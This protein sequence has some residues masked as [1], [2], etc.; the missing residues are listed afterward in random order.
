MNKIIGV[1]ICFFLLS[2]NFLLI[3]DATDTY[4]PLDGGWLEIK[5][6]VKI[7]HLSGT[8]YEMGYQHGFLL[9][10]EIPKNIRML[11]TLFESRGMSYDELVNKW[12]ILKE[13]I[14]MDYKN[15]LRGLV[16]S[17]GLTDEEIGVLNIC[18][19]AVNLIHCCGGITWG[20]ATI[21]GELIHLRSGD[22]D[23]FLND[24]ETG[25]F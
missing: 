13:Y 16:D 3:T 18:H 17:S 15:E 11:K 8:N 4:N 6:G 21:N 7:L 24:S 19:D 23:I 9:K 2:S 10:D 5:D 22:M 12:E 14:P 1:F 25:T 20:D